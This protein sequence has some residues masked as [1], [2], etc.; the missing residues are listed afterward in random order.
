MNIGDLLDTVDIAVEAGKV[1]EFARA[2][3]ATDPVHVDS[4]AAARAGFESAPATLT[5]SVVTGHQR[6]QREF[7]A[8]L[9]LALDR[10]V[11]GSVSWE[12]ARPLLVGDELHA[13][14]RVEGDESKEGRSGPMR[15]VTLV[16]TFT[17]ARG[18]VA[19][20]QRET[21]IERGAAS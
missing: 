3:G 14:R 15:I 6:D 13:E 17:D 5:H 20:T 1:R 10:I 12:Y 11:V 2:T 21:L 9:G 16:T 7:V 18:E 4:A 8:A 19:L